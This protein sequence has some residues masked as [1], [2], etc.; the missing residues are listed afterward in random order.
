[1]GLEF[2][3]NELSTVE[4]APDIAIAR[5]RMIGLAETIRAAIPPGIRPKAN[6]VLRTDR[7]FLVSNLGPEYPFLKWRNDQSVDREVRQ[8]LG[9]LASKGPFIDEWRPTLSADT[10]VEFRLGD[11]AVKGLAL[12]F[13][14]DH[15]AVSLLSAEKWDADAI[16]LSVDTLAGDD[17]FTS[18][19]V[20]VRHASRVVHLKTH[21]DWIVTRVEGDLE[22]GEALADKSGILFPQ[23]EFCESALAQLRELQSGHR[24][25]RQILKKLRVM[26]EYCLAWQPATPFNPGSF[27]FRVTPE[28]QATLDQYGTLRT[29]RCPDGEPRLFSWHAR[30]TPDSWRLYF[31]PEPSRTT[32]VVGY[33]GPHLPTVDYP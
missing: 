10:E 9:F 2:V 1:L 22:A 17:E 25:I 14:E 11:A 29:F 15:L 23:L 20:P 16:E 12:A 18:E 4:P 5:E 26:N 19:T 28:S 3:L 24:L 7:L 6:P 30:L 31:R 21:Q 13:S 32:L 8:Y 33:F 27:G